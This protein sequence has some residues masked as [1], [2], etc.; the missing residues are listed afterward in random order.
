[1]SD[2]RLTVPILL[3]P[4][5]GREREIAALRDLLQ[6]VHLRLLTLT[7]P[8]GVGKTRLA[9]QLAVDSNAGASSKEKFSE[10]VEFVPLA[11]ITN[12]DLVLSTIAQTL[13]IQPTNR[14]LLEQLATH[15]SGERLLV[16]DNFEQITSAAP[17]LNQLLASC[18]GLKIL[19]TSRASLHLSG[20]HEFPVLPLDPLPAAE[21]FNLRAHAIQPDFDA[22]GQNAEVIANI[23]QQ[24]DGLPLAIELAAARDPSQVGQPLI[25]TDGWRAGYADPP[26]KFARRIGLESQPAGIGGTTPLPPPRAVYWRLYIGCG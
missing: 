4:L 1:M 11:P 26:P 5:I 22:A 9:L 3:T 21:L 6:D 18:P 25:R 8:G 20:E 7:G 14:P 12:P 23:C 19:V 13:G 17:I 2:T 16:L 10:G 15:L 24:L